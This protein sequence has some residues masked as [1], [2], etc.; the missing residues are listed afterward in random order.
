MASN[1]VVISP[2]VNITEKIEEFKEISFTANLTK[3]SFI[4]N[5][6]CPAIINKIPKTPVENKT[7][8]FIVKKNN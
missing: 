5:D 7:L 8:L 4:E 6:S 3:L 2:L 1:E